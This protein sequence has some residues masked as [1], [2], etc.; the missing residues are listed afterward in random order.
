MKH[1]RYL[2]P[3]YKSLFRWIGRPIFRLI[4]T[5]LSPIE[6]LGKENIPQR[7]AYIMVFNHVSLYDA[8]L[9]IAIWPK[10]LEALGAQDIWSRPGQ[11]TLAKLYGVIPVLRGE[12]DRDSIFAVLAALR[13][14]RP[15][16][17]APEGGRS[18]G[19]GMA[20]AKSGI[21]YFIEAVGVPV[22]PVGI[23]GTTDDYFRR[24]SHGLRPTVRVIVGKPFSLPEELGGSAISP[25]DARRIKVDYIMRHIAALLP[26]DYRGYYA[27]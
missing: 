6:F 26:E 1:G 15:L 14:G 20:Q 19:R 8:P 25:K 17:M 2:L 9:L 18:H 16:M 5:I 24:G 4:F 12:V 13:N 21:V 22:L 27:S 3:W 23:V 11:S 7:G 10:A